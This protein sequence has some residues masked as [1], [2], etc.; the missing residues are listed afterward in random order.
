[1][2]EFCEIVNKKMEISFAKLFTGHCFIGR[3]RK[4][5]CSRDRLSAWNGFREMPNRCVKLDTRYA[6]H[7]HAYAR[8]WKGGG[9]RYLGVRSSA[10]SLG[11]S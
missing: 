1:M 6:I 11:S 2:L 8:A 4:G 3:D 9:S 7:V 10:S 5:A